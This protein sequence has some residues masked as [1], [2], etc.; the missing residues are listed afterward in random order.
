MDG[1]LRFFAIGDVSPVMDEF[2]TV[3]AAHARD[4]A[5]LVVRLGRVQVHGTA[6]AEGDLLDRSQGL[7][8]FRH[9]RAMVA[10]TLDTIDTDRLS[11]VALA[12]GDLKKESED[13]LVTRAI[14][15]LLELLRYRRNA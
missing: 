3:K 4:A 14:G 7:Y 10:Y 8:T 6:E 13:A 5:Y 11:V 15:R 2:L 12:F 9:R 1:G